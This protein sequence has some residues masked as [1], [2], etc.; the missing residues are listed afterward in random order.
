MKDAIGFM[1]REAWKAKGQPDCD[2]PELVKEYSFPGT[3]TGYYL[4]P[5]CGQRMRTECAG[6]D[7]AVRQPLMPE[8]VTI[9]Q[10]SF[11]DATAGIKARSSHGDEDH[12]DRG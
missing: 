11:V 12:S 7:Q 2:H 5:T 1:L 9:V 4:C 10:D 8:P 3:V 6:K